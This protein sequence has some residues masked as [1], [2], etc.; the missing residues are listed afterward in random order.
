[1]VSNIFYFHP[2]L[3]KIPILTNIFEM[4]WNHQPEYEKHDWSLSSLKHI[5]FLAQV[6]CCTLAKISQ[7]SRCSGNGKKE[8]TQKINGW[9]PEKYIPAKGKSSDPNHHFFLGS[10]LVFG[11]VSS[12]YL[13]GICWGPK[14]QRAIWLKRKTALGWYYF[15]DFFTTLR[16]VKL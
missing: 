7:G 1:M 10:M 14:P 2:Y 15:R 5:F 13:V 6:L 12:R 11:G 16:A 3:G 9:E 8:K 4:G